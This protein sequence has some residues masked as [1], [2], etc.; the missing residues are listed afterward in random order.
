MLVT[1]TKLYAAEEHKSL[2]G[3]VQACVLVPM[4]FLVLLYWLT[5]PDGLIITFATLEVIAQK[6]D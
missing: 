6:F 3:L 2:T 4:C 1:C 5:L